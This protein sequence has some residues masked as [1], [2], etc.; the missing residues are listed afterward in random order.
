M[1]QYSEL[2]CVIPGQGLKTLFRAKTY[3]QALAFR[4]NHALRTYKGGKVFAG[5]RRSE[6]IEKTGWLL[7]ESL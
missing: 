7:D 4:S 5:E 6:T 1:H 2:Q 3:A